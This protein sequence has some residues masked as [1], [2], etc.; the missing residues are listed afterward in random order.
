MII[1]QNNKQG[2][3]DDVASNEIE[4]KILDVFRAK[5]NFTTS[6]SEI[7]SWKN[8]MMY[9]HNVLVDNEIPAD[10]GVA[11]EYKIPMTSKRVDFILS[12]KNALL[13]EAAVIIELK[14]WSETKKTDSDGIVLTYLGGREREVVHPSYQAWSY[15][16]II[17]DFNEAIYTDG[18]PLS[19]CA[20]LHNLRREHDV[21][22]DP[23]YAEYTLKAPIFLREDATKLR[24]FIRSNIKHGDNGSTI[25]KLDGG[26]IKPSKSL[27]DKVSSLL[28]GNQEF[29]MIDD[30]KIVFE[31]I[32]S[33]ANAIN[34]QKKVVIVEG[35]PGTGKTVVAMNLLSHLLSAEKTAQYVT[36]NSAPRTVYEAKLKGDFK[37]SSIS[38][39]FSGSGAFTATEPNTFDVLI[40]DEAHR[41][42]EK[43]GMFMNLGEN[44]IKEVINA[45]H[46]TVFFIDESQRV[47]LKDIGSKGEIRKW[48]TEFGAQIV[49]TE[50]TSQFRCNGSDGY[51]SWLDNLLQIRATANDTLDGIDYD[52]RVVSSPAELRDLIYE[53]NEINNR[54]RLVAGYCW[55]WISKGSP[56]EYDIIFDEYDFKMKWNLADDGM[57]WIMKESSVDQIGCVHT[58]QGLELDYVGV[59]IGPDMT[60]SN[61]VIQTSASK[62]SRQDSTIK[63]YKGLLKEDPIK[64]ELF[65]DEIIKNTYRTLMTRGMKG[66]YVYC[67]DEALQEYISQAS[68]I[69]DNR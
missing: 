6:N 10:C 22:N 64:A 45:A 66:C 26:R 31:A 29:V 11:I 41:L 21:L 23:F 44:Q 40:V 3:L 58:C 62:R 39:L 13:K 35:G 7:E 48:A 12:G 1:Y 18:V 67:V 5:L 20:Y 8:S 46:T 34:T 19:P 42:N 68:L 55:D 43:S 61:G 57:L 54:S 37:K 9:M 4:L 38:N 2:F 36:K 56:Q 27:A 50:L 47:S 69:T 16:N 65:A 25:A 33:T 24:E 14:Q 30:Q 28:K 52:F 63:G 60:F 17:S 51:I 15:A 59:I 53:K 49:E 32:L